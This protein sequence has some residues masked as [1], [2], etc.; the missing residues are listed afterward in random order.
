M[1]F[2]CYFILFSPTGSRL[3]D[4]HDIFYYLASSCHLAGI[5]AII[6]THPF[7]GSINP[8]R[9]FTFEGIQI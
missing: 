7:S 5:S 9:H 2:F 1:I 6:F 8:A 4:F 3:F